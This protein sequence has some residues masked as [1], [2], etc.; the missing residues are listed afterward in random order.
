G[1]IDV[2]AG[3]KSLDEILQ[4]DPRSGLRFLPA[5]AKPNLPH[6]NELLASD[7]M[8]KLIT[9]LKENYDYLIVD[10]PPLIPVV[11]ARASTNFVDAYICTVEWGVTKVD[12][13][14][15]A[16][17]NAPEIFERLLG[18]ILNKVDM[19][20]IGRYER[21]RNDFYYD[22]YRSRY[23]AQTA[24]G[25][26]KDAESDHRAFFGSVSEALKSRA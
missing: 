6:T 8:K 13:V 3:W 9:R 26:E 12:L 20:R 25:S 17:L 15:H 22:K 16:L 10:L 7:A 14:R 19:T 2:L 18:V 5:G 23:G 4:L 21:Y 11:D 1:L 24:Q